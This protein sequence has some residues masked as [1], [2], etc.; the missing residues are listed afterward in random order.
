M[1]KFEQFE[2][3]NGLKV[4]VHEDETTTMAAVNI[5]YKV[6][7]RNETSDQTGFAHLF[8]HFMFEGS[9][10]IPEFDTPL[11]NAS[12]ENNAF[13]SND[14]T[15]YYDIL[16]ANNLETAFWLESDR[17][18]SL[19]FAEESLTTQKNVV[20]EEFKEHYINQP[21]GDVWHKMSA[22][23]Y[24]VHPYQWP[25]IGKDLSH[26]EKVKMQ[27]AKDFFFKYYRPNNAVMV[28]AG[29]VKTAEVKA[30]AE[31]WFGEIPA[32]ETIVR[33]IPKEP[34]QNEERV[35]EV[36]ADVPV[37]AIYK[38]YKVC[39]RRDED[40]Q[41]T[42]LLRD[43][44]SSGD[45]SRLYQKLVKDKKLFSNISAYLSETVDEGLLMIDGRLSE[46]VSMDDANKAIE[47]VVNEI[48]KEKISDDELTKVKNKIEA[49]MT[50]SDTNILNRAMNLAYFEMLGNPDEV[51]KEID[52]YK[53]VTAD[54]LQQVASKVFRKENCNTIR[55]FSNN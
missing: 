52:K 46:G 2:L 28:V 42:D 12:G 48:A 24:K 26:I 34:E 3:K 11:Q 49:L 19:A 27:S 39:A 13:T 14:I 45:S 51:N 33:D 15:N 7:S 18:L 44:L 17:M 35:L 55:Y 37:N 1:I 16:P 30:L 6:G 36:K 20:M 25:V 50:F 40:Y 23:A 10:N 22:L 53:A 54:K 4:I 41:A 47:E 5:L 9:V 43:I 21:Y 38:G 31:K 29:N 8:E 32:G